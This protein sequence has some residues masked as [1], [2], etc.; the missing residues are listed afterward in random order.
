MYKKTNHLFKVI[1]RKYPKGDNL[2][3]HK[4]P[5][6]SLNIMDYPAGLK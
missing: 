5:E 2:N 1:D 4:D 6:I 3:Y